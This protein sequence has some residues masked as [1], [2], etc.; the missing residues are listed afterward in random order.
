ML[1]SLVKHDII[2]IG[3]SMRIISGGHEREINVLTYFKLYDDSDKLN[4]YL[5]YTKDL[6]DDKKTLYVANLEY[7]DNRIYLVKPADEIIEDLKKII[8]SL[9]SDSTN[10]FV[11]TKCE[12]HYLDLDI[13][14]EVYTEE[15]TVLKLGLTNDKFESLSNN[16]FL[17][18]PFSNVTKSN[19]KE[20]EYLSNNFAAFLF[21]SI[22]L[23]LMYVGLIIY[24][25]RSDEITKFMDFDDMKTLFLF[26]KFNI[27]SLFIIKISI[28]TMILSCIAYNNDDDHPGILFLFIT[29]IFMIV[30]VIYYKTLGYLN[31]NDMSTMYVY[32][33]IL[34]ISFVQS[35]IVTIPY[36][37]FKKIINNITNTIKVKNYVTFHTLFLIFS[38]PV[39]LGLV[40]FYN[41]YLYDGV[42]SFIKGIII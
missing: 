15:K 25:F 42:Y 12:Y 11:F 34:A 3:G 28:I 38:I 31:L 33:L 4:E 18:Y 35:L 29:L 26:F 37:I 10:N 1:K 36:V 39:F 17:T 30:Y 21:S 22:L 2:K 41:I 32:K 23:I 16:K 19:L 9:I 27:D 5:F 24:H 14:D 7:K 8:E 40:K 13:I 20:N 6:E